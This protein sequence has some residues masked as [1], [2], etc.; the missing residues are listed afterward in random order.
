[1]TGRTLDDLQHLGQEEHRLELP[2]YFA[3]LLLDAV[4]QHLFAAAV[5][6]VARLLPDDAHFHLVL[7]P[8]AEVGRLQPGHSQRFACLD[9]IDQL[10]VSFCVEGIQRGKEVNGLE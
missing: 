6:S 9:E 2:G 3:G 7:A 1:V 8:A 10:A 4:E 5:D